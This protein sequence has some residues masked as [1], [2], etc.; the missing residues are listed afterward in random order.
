LKQVF[1]LE[2]SIL[3]YLSWPTN[4]NVNCSHPHSKG[5]SLCCLVGV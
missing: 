2:F 5:M 1:F 4:I 3:F